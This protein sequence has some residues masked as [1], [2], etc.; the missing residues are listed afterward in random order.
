MRLLISNDDGVYAPGLAAL[1]GALADFADCSVVAPSEDQSGVGSALTLDRPLY[2]EQVA[3]GWI[4]INGT[5]ADCV[6]L[7][8]DGLLAEPP[9]MVVSGINLGANLGDDVLYSG[10]VAAAMEGRFLSRTAFAFSLL[11]KK[12]THL[13]TAAHFARLLVGAHE[14]LD[15]PPRTV[16]NVNVPD[17]PLEQIRGIRATRLGQRRRAAAPLAHVNPRGKQGFWLAV[18]GEVED[19]SEGTDFHAVQQGF[20]SVTPLQ[21]GR[22]ELSLDGLKAWLL[23]LLL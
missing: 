2:P 17:L 16:L 4:S 12:T 21:I 3:D 13:P 20:V 11:S 14:R 23:E 6:H 15:L 9:D 10:T 18:A 1:H 19:G 8:L 5:P 7:G 22:P